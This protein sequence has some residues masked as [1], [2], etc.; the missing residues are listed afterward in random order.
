MK[1]D[2][3]LQNLYTVT[4]TNKYQ[5]LCK[6]INEQLDSTIQYFKFFEANNNTANKLLPIKQKD[7]AVRNAND[8]FVAKARNK[9]NSAFSRLQNDPSKKNKQNL[10]IKKRNL[11][12]AYEKTEA[13][14]L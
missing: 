6:Q 5:Q 13:D 14:E 4:I 7:K 3:N 11:L 12:D 1:D 10:K 9:I 2:A 8:L